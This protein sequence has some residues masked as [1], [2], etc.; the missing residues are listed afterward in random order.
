MTRGSTIIKTSITMLALLLLL[1]GCGTDDR[2]VNPQ[3]PAASG[4]ANNVSPISKSVSTSDNGLTEIQFKD[5]FTSSATGDGQINPDM[6]ELHGKMVGIHGYMTELTPIDNRFIYLVPTA[7]AACPF[8]STDNPKYM[9][10]IAVYVKDGASVDFTNQALWAYGK[11]EIGEEAD[12]ATGLISMY[13]LVD[14]SVE[15]YQAR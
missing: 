14:A 2:T 1:I 6:A 10:A 11:L 8:C 15:P 9:E 4:I 12:E 7:G 13:R 3:E 5:F